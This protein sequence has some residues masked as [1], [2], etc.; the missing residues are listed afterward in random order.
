ME[1]RNPVS[2]TLAGK[3]ALFYSRGKWGDVGISEGT[4]IVGMMD[5]LPRAYVFIIGLKSQVIDTDEIQAHIEKHI[6]RFAHSYEALRQYLQADRTAEESPTE[7]ARLLSEFQGARKT[8]LDGENFG[9]IVVR[10]RRDRHPA[11]MAY[12]GLPF[13]LVGHFLI[14]ALHGRSKSLD[15]RSP[16]TFRM[17]DGD[18]YPHFFGEYYRRD[19]QKLLLS[20][21]D[22]YSTQYTNPRPRPPREYKPETILRYRRIWELI[23]KIPPEYQQRISPEYIRSR[24]YSYIPNVPD[25][26]WYRG[27]APTAAANILAYWDTRDYPRLVDDPVK[28]AYDL[29]DELADAMDT[30]SSGSTKDH[31]VDDGIEAVCNDPAYNNNYAFDTDGPDSWYCWGKI[32]EA[33][34]ADRPCHLIVHG[35]GTYGDHSVTVVGYRRV[36]KD[37]AADDYFVTIHDTWLIPGYDVEIPYE[38]SVDGCD[39]D[40]QVTQ[41]DPGLR[42]AY[43]GCSASDSVKQAAADDQRVLFRL[44]AS[45]GATGPLAE[46]FRILYRDAVL[47]EEFNTIVAASPQKMEDFGR[48]LHFSAYLVQAMVKGTAEEHLIFPSQTATELVAIL[49]FVR[50]KASPE[51]KQPLDLMIEGLKELAGNNVAQMRRKLLG[52]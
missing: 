8:L 33:V 36:V 9:T 14:L 22:G 41:V 45:E 24:A 7:G 19:G 28:T 15:I 44:L 48:H 29:I 42:R 47:S 31:N 49:D 12:E 46:G 39:T 11:I 10:A 43:T 50:T 27:C 25:L 4:P 32:T 20:L 5:N 37:C 17:G 23:E 40:W 30:D 2:K 3:A 16:A 6:S 13:T 34:D 1:R 26:L 21:M 51:L 52:K 18:G 35:H 38:G